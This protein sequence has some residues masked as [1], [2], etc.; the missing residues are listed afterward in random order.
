MVY[1][2]LIKINSKTKKL[3]D[4]LKLVKEEHYNTVIERLILTSSLTGGT[5]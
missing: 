5:L 2:S 1:S 3:L 4:E